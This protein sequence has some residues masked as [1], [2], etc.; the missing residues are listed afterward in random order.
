RGWYLSTS[1]DQL[2][3][4]KDY[5]Y[6]TEAVVQPALLRAGQSTARYLDAVTASLGKLAASTG[7]SLSF[8]RSGAGA[9]V[10]GHSGSTTVSGAAGVDVLPAS[11]AHG[12][13]L[14]L[15]WAY[16]APT[17]QLASEQRALASVAGCYG[18]ERGTLLSLYKDTNFTYALPPGWKPSEQP[19]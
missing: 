14:A 12:S 17:G 9:T 1:G 18:V 5:S 19:D 11:T 2:L 15:A 4:Y 10:A 6:E 7:K 3:V 8:R 13:S 16:W